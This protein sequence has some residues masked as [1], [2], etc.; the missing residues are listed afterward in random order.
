MRA[1]TDNFRLSAFD[2]KSKTTYGPLGCALISI[3]AVTNQKSNE[4]LCIAF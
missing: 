2:P 1:A 4:N 3:N